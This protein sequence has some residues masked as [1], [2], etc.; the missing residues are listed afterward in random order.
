MWYISKDIK[1]KTAIQKLDN[2]D[3]KYVMEIGKKT[4]EFFSQYLTKENNYLITDNYQEDRKEKIVPRTSST[5]IGLSLLAVISAY[6]LKYINLDECLE[7]LVNIIKTIE[8]LP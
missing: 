8:E 5:N 3:K 2:Q 1:K 4:R 7:M 6:D